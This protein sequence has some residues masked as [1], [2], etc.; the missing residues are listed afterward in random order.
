MKKDKVRHIS[1]LLLPKIGKKPLGNAARQLRSAFSL[2]A[3]AS[4]AGSLM[5]TQGKLKRLRN[6][7][8]RITFIGS[9]NT[10]K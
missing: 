6:I 3:V 5:A 7:P 2:K 9:L 10:N 1:P 4:V 8:Q